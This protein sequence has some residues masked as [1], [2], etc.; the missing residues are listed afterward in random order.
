MND[1]TLQII[2]AIIGSGILT[3]LVS[4]AV[5]LIS[6]SIDKKSGTQAQITK[7][8]KKLDE[9]IAQSYRNKILNFQNELL[10]KERHSF[11]QFSE[12]LDAIDSYEAYCKENNVTNHKCTL[13]I[14][15][16][17]SVY[18]QCQCESDFAPMNCTMISEAELKRMI[19]NMNQIGNV[20]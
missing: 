3:S 14:D 16:I 20:N 6:K 2:L 11:E 7:I 18:K 15:Y 10:R 13:A 19:N 4:G 5:T 1:S 8:E 12:V 17:K 9:H